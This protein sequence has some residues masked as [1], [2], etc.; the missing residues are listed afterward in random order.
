METELLGTALDSSH[1]V[2]SGGGGILG[3]AIALAVKQYLFNGKGKD[4]SDSSKEFA[5]LGKKVD[6]LGEKLDKPLQSILN[7]I[8]DQNGFIRGVMSQK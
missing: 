2:T 8:N 3:A 5:E 7:S 6:D 4:A 1:G